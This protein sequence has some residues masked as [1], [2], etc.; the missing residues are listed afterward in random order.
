MQALTAAVPTAEAFLK[1]T[2][3]QVAGLVL[4]LMNAASD[5]RAHPRTLRLDAERAYD[6]PLS[7]MAGDLIAAAVELMFGERFIARD[8]RDVVDN[9]WFALTEKGKT[10][11]TPESIE[12]PTTLIDSGRPLVFISC[13]QYTDAEK[14]I[15]VKISDIIRSHTDYVPYFAENQRSFEGLSNS[16]L[17]ALHRMCAMVV[18]MHKRG[19]VKTPHDRFHRGSVWVEQEI[20][21]AAAMQH[22]GRDII[23]AAYVQDGIKRE[24]LR[25][26]LHL[27]PISFIT[28]DDIAKHFESLVV[29]GGF[30]LKPTGGSTNVAPA[31]PNRAPSPYEAEATE[32]L[33]HAAGE[34][35]LFILNY[36]CS[37][38]IA[39]HPT[40]FLA[41]RFS[42]DEMREV[43]ESAKRASGVAF[44]IGAT[45]AA[46]NLDDGFAVTT[47]PLSNGPRQCREY[48]RFRRDGLFVAT[49]VSPDDI[50]ED[51]QYRDRDRCIG[52]T[53][54]VGT[55]TRMGAFAAAFAMI[56]G[57]ETKATLRI[58]GLANHRLIDDSA[59]RSLTIGEPLVAH[60]DHLVDELVA[61]PARLRRENRDWSARVITQSLRLLNYPATN[62]IIEATVR[63]FQQRVH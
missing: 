20:A 39:I 52:F 50:T 22:A 55:L 57:V 4:S 61:E 33:K 23:V 30:A 25:D 51:R 56:L 9:D 24:G 60:E 1:L 16:I 15:G 40:M 6:G 3:R 41:D 29:H 19:E 63:N 14:A 31:S 26:L 43:I 54:L 46:A 34:G 2:P 35:G 38:S 7:R 42:D 11:L 12:E 21:I 37:M 13:G 49:Q 58:S 5:K 62:A 45:S 32:A 17:A 10:I 36:V 8:Y 27:N 47:Y 44:P 48:Y 59:E 18:I 53:T 28:E